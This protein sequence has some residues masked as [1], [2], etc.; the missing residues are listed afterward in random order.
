MSSEQKRH[1]VKGQMRLLLLLTILFLTITGCIV[2]M[3]IFNQFIKSQTYDH[4]ESAIQVLEEY[5]IYQ[6]SEVAVD[7]AQRIAQMLTIQEESYRNS[8]KDYTQLNQVF[9]N[10]AFSIYTSELEIEYSNVSVEL[11]LELIK[12]MKDKQQSVRL[13]GNEDVGLFVLGLS[14]VDRGPSMEPSYV[15]TY[16]TLTNQKIIQEMHDTFDVVITIFYEDMRVVTSVVQDDKYAVGSRLNP[17][18][19]QN[20][21][22]KYTHYEGQTRVLGIPYLTIYKSIGNMDEAPIGIIAVGHPL[23]DFNQTKNTILLWVIFLGSGL[24]VAS[25]IFSNHWLEQHIIKPLNHTT[26]VL[27]KAAIGKE[28]VELLQES[29]DYL[30]FSQL[31]RSIYTVVKDLQDSHL[32]IEKIAYYDEL[33]GLPN[34]FYL[35]H[36]HDGLAFT[37]DSSINHL[38]YLDADNLKRVNDLYGHR[39]GDLLISGIA[40]FL[41][42]I[43]DEYPSYE[44]YRVGGDEFIIAKTGAVNR[45]ELEEM[46]QT[47]IHR[48]KAPF[49]SDDFV[50]SVTFSIG[51]ASAKSED[52]AG[53]LDGLMQKAEI[54]MYE[55]KE[56]SKNDYMFYNP[57][58][59]E[60]LLNRQELEEELNYA[61]EK[62]ELFLVYQPK[63]DI[64]G[65]RAGSVEA[66][67]RWKNRKRGVVAPN[68]FIDIAEETGL[69]H[70]IGQWVLEEACRFLKKM[71]E[72]Y[73]KEF[74]VAVNVSAIQLL[75]DDF[76]KNVFETLMKYNIEPKYLELEITESVLIDFLESS[77]DKLRQL[78]ALGIEIAI[79]DFGK[80]YSSLAY[81]TE[82]PI[83]TVKID[84]L[85]VDDIGFKDNSLVA[86]IIDIG[87]RMNLNVV[88]EG[89]ETKT[90][91]EYLKEAKCDIIQGYYYSKPLIEEEAKRFLLKQPKLE[92]EDGR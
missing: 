32:S 30:E 50:L 20:L 84:K 70:P 17:E 71:H 64:N 18:M 31:R 35:Y 87:H 57:A 24:F 40:R 29:D 19:S 33:T 74:K 79:D 11:P 9:E 91:V 54:A 8:Q 43:I 65:K 85:F 42:S 62:N 21:L 69:I 3:I 36:K 27:T 90:Q 46:A 6:P 72:D 58:M 81:L 4:L 25:V 16:R 23:T 52:E 73:S 53:A 38:I 28:E 83:T 47:I 7:D 63:Y 67:V 60:R 55:V 15:V 89:V 1:S 5:V 88:A 37:G 56:N 66:L 92:E 44:L 26:H 48:F 82:L 34:R 49:Y 22:N 51:I 75:R 76:V 86:D 10:T 41:G 45:K 80:G 2:V 68:E 61:L 77:V 78:Y 13:S 14:T 12:D 39:V 59:T